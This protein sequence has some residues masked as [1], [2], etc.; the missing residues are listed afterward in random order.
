MLVRNCLAV[1]NVKTS[2]RLFKL[3]ILLSCVT[4]EDHLRLHSLIHKTLNK[5]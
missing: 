5:K 4:V 3:N 1:I 2:V